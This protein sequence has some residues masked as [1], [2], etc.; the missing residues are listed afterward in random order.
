MQNSDA[1]SVK[2]A[3]MGSTPIFTPRIG[4]VHVLHTEIRIIFVIFLLKSRFLLLW[5]GGL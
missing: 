5:G 1:I 3:E 2:P 4:P